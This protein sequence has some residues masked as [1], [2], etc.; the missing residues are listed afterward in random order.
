[1][2]DE[3][4]RRCKVE[5]LVPAELAIRAAMLV[6]E[7]MPA[8]MRLTRAVVLL[9]EA[10]DRVADF[11]DGVS[12]P[13]PAPVG[14][15]GDLVERTFPIQ[16]GLPIPWAAAEQAYREYVKHGGA[17]QSLERLA[18]RGGFALAEWACLYQGHYPGAYH[19]KCIQRAVLAVAAPPIREQ[20]LRDRD[21][22]AQL[23]RDTWKPC[24]YCGPWSAVPKDS[25]T[26]CVATAE[27]Q[28]RVGP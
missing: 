13:D 9:Q 27:L 26:H 22:L 7:E 18:E 20:A 4:P 21:E 12:V 16:D 5:R 14:A 10:R 11:V 8:D 3:I 2:S 25:C 28:R 15:T 1:M 17:G 6:V 23:V 24:V 19:G